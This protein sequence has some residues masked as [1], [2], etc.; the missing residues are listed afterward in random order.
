VKTKVDTDTQMPTTAEQHVHA[1]VLYQTDQTS[2]IKIKT[3]PTRAL[4]KPKL[5]VNFSSK[6]SIQ[7]ML[8]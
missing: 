5:K 8:D 7:E 2:S 1:E 4:G 3:L 6:A